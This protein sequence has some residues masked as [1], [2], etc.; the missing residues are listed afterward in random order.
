VD[1]DFSRWSPLLVFGGIWSRS[2][3]SSAS[4]RKRTEDSAAQH[5]RM[6]WR[7]MLL[8]AGLSCAG[9]AHAAAGARARVGRSRVACIGVC[10]VAARAG[11]TVHV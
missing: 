5:L 1:R 9:R 8:S 10:S 7:A 4:A 6:A 11:A 2:S 3:E